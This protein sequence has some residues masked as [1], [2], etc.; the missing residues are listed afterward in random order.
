MV[1]LDL[2][3]QV[4]G[5]K[6]ML[7]QPITRSEWTLKPSEQNRSDGISQKQSYKM[8]VCLSSKRVYKYKKKRTIQLYQPM[9]K[10]TKMQK[11]IR[12]SKRNR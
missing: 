7:V 11:L 1:Y 5:L 2:N 10:F 3:L 12:N 9:T 4:N 8:H 6:I